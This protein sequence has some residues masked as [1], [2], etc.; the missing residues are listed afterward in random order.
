MKIRVINYGYKEETQLPIRNFYNDAG[1]D[2]I[3]PI[4]TVIPAHGA[5]K[6]PLRM[7][8]RLPD[9]FMLCN[10]PK[11]GMS[12]KGICSQIPPIDS[13]YT[14]EINAILTNVTDN[15]FPIQK[16]QKV[17]QLVMLPIIFAEFIPEEEMPSQDS[18]GHNGFGST[19]L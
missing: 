11:S 16:G 18:R 7:G 1:A 12:S 17:A 6:I 8:F 19:G 14:G 15:D 10:F 9:G 4:D 13:G 5:V 3:S 2:V